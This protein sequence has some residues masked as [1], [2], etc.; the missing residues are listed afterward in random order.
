MRDNVKFL[1]EQSSSLIT[2]GFELV[3]PA[4]LNEAKMLGLDLPYDLPCL[5]DIVKFAEKKIKR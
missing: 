5:Q 4:M 2:C 1:D 3:F